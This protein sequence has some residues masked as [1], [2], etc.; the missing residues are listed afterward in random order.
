MILVLLLN[1]QF[2]HSVEC[3]IGV[4]GGNCRLRS[5]LSLLKLFFIT[6]KNIENTPTANAVGMDGLMFIGEKQ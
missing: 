4:P 5:A 3:N 6:K 2:N 1:H